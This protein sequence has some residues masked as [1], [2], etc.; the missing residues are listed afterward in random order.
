[1][2]VLVAAA[3]RMGTPQNEFSTGTLM[4]PPPR[5]SSPEIAPAT[6]D[7]ASATGRRRTR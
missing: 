5:P 3:T 4:M 1:M 6:P 2:N 7:A